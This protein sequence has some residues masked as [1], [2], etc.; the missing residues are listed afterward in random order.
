M[1]ALKCPKCPSF[2]EKAAQDTVGVD[3]CK[4]C[5]GIWVGFIEEKALLQIKPE[6]M[7]LDEIRR[8]RRQY[9]PVYKSEPV[10]Y[11]PCPACGDLMTRRNWGSHSGIIVE[12]CESHG[13]WFDAGE[14]EKIRNFIQLGGIEYEKIRTTEKAFTRMESKLSQ[15]ILRL[16]KRVD[17]AYARARLWSIFT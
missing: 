1:T 12:R 4:S 3:H 7:T 16:D 15:E 17:S 2:L 10:R 9:Q 13:T 14:V 5:K 6:T 11:V 8:L